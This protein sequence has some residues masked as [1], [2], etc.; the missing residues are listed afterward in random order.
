[1]ARKAGRFNLIVVP[2][3]GTHW[4]EHALPPAAAIARAARA[5]LRLVLVH[6]LPAPPTDRESLKIYTSSEV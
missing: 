4:A 5:K 6:Q 2:L 3:D 1:L